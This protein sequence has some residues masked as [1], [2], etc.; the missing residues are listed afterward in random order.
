MSMEQ[1][2]AGLPEDGLPASSQME[3]IRIG[4]ARRLGFLLCQENNPPGH[5]SRIFNGVHLQQLVFPNLDVL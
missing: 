5:R 4:G 1:Q 3:G 2:L